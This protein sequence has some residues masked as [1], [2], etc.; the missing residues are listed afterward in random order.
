ALGSAGILDG[1]TDRVGT[2]ASAAAGT[3]AGLAGSAAD[4]IRTAARPRTAWPRYVAIVVALAAIIWAVSS[5]M[6]PRTGRPAPQATA[7]TTNGNTTAGA[8]APG[9]MTVGD[10]DVGKTFT[11]VSDGLTQTMKDIKDSDTAKAAVP[12]LTDLTNK[13]DSLTPLVG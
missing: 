6:G 2:G 1:L 11:S 7:P 8:A 9:N 10:V 4:T 5:Y 13:L 3:A 12:K